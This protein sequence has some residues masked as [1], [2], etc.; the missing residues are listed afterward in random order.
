M[1]SN[2][3]SQSKKPIYQSPV[4]GMVP[5]R[6]ALKAQRSFGEHWHSEIEIFYLMPGSDSISVW[7]EEKQYRLKE[8]DM[9]IIPPAAVH[10][11]EVTTLQ[12]PLVLRLDV[13]F[14]LLGGNFRPFTERRFVQLF[15]SF[16]EEK[17]ADMISVESILRSIC[18]ERFVLNGE[19]AGSDAK[20]FIDR[21]RVSALLF[22]L[23]AEL[24]RI[25]PTEPIVQPVNKK[26][27][28]QIINTVIYYFHEHYN[29]PF[30]LFSAA[31]MAGYEKTNFC[32]LFK[33]ITGVSFHKYIC[34]FRLEKALPLLKN[35]ELPIALIAQSVGIPSVKS[36]SR[37]IKAKYGASPKEIRD[38]SQNK[39]T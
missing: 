7:I 23:M 19:A 32:H 8:R 20:S 11:I 35:T 39:M 37:L 13:G 25:L 33:D 15:Y 17:N 21:M 5:F 1:E 34:S 9:L 14:P 26:H 24:L 10:K 22:Q 2:L 18:G 36:F 38:N 16:S 27:A 29:E 30:T 28:L 31:V 3:N 6:A 12:T 4:T